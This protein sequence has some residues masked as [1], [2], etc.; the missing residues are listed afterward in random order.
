MECFFHSFVRDNDG[1]TSHN[2]LITFI[3]PD[4]GITFRAAFNG[5]PYEVEY[6]ALLALLEFVQDNPQLFKN[7]TIE[8]YSDSFTV[9]N[10]VNKK[11]FCSKDLEPFRNMA[12]LMMNKIPYSLNLI[13]KNDNPA[14]QAMGL[15]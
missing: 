5:E 9:V 10:Q 15:Y 6:A 4:I 14:T 2:S 1:A 8:I 7:R 13:P 11:M 3:V 12:L